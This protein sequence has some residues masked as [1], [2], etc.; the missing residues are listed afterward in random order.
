MSTMPDLVG[1]NY[2]TAVNTLILEQLIP[3]D[4]SVPVS[5]NPLPTAEYFGIWPL[6]VLYDADSEPGVVVNQF[7]PAGASVSVQSTWGPGETYTPS[8]ALQVGKPAMAVSGLFW[9]GAFDS[10]AV[11]ALFEQMSG[12]VGVGIVG[13]QIVGSTP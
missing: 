1:L 10:G 9:A 2:L 11:Q 6:A 5:A 12:L 13:L 8:I 7:P 3:N 4:G